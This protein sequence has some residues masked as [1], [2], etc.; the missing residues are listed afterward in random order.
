MADSSGTGARG[1]SHPE[2]T[3]SLAEFGRPTRLP[4]SGGWLLERP[5]PGERAARDLLGPYPVFACGDWTSLADDLEHLDRPAVSVVLVAD[6]LAD[7]PEAELR[8]AFP[9]LLIPFKRH[10][11]RDLDSPAEPPSHHRRHIRRAG[12]SV[13]VE[14]CADPLDR[15]DDWSDLYAQLVARHGLEGI[16]AF[17]RDAF[18]R[19]LGLP[20]TVALRAHQDGR[21]VAMTIWFENA[22]HAYY[23]LGASSA[24]GY[25]VNAS[26]A[27]FDAAFDHLRARG[28]R[29]VDLGAAPEGTD[30]AAQQ[31]LLRFKQGWANAERPARLCGRILER[32]TYREL[33]ERHA[34]GGGDWFPAYRAAD[35][36]LA[37]PGAEA[38][39]GGVPR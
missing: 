34:P 17:S 35:S 6:P 4:R 10:L 33:T 11:V 16:R 15:L 7:P 18:R 37:G 23:H 39:E 29:L 14:V 5:V 24:E 30:D 12:R 13:E 26:Y 1:Y 25:A 22:P 27:L 32:E 28:V 19:Q 20:G 36:D 2:Y 31:G 8:R 21:T 9:D 38:L 3:A